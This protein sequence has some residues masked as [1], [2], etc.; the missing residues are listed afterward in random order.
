[1]FTFL[2]LRPAIR[3]AWGRR[4]GQSTD[5]V[6]VQGMSASAGD[7]VSLQRGTQQCQITDQI[8]KFVARG[9][10]RESRPGEKALWAN[11]KRIVDGR[12]PGKP[13]LPQRVELVGKSPRPGWC[14]LR[15]KPL[16][17]G[18]KVRDL[19][20]QHGVIKRDDVGRPKHLG[21]DREY[22]GTLRGEPHR[23]RDRV[24]GSGGVL[25]NDTRSGQRLKVRS[26][27]SV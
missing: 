14:K 21:G 26:Y 6:D 11:P 15:G 1:M 17:A 2:S 22:P 13:S 25:L 3:L 16:A 5:E 19:G 8:H 4:A 23:I 9:L 27:A 10:I 18:I 24:N 12:A 7:D 20:A